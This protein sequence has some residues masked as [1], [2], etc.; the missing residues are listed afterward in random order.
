MLNIYTGRIGQTGLDITVKSGDKVFAPTWDIVMNLKN[1]NITWQQY[2]KE[3]YALMRNSYQI[4]H[5][6]WLEILNK[7]EVTFLCYCTD[8]QRCHRTLLVDMFC[9]LGKSESIQVRYM[10]ERES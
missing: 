5:E 2:V 6:R 4:N 8:P 9:K 3:Y 1:G 7:N 10:G